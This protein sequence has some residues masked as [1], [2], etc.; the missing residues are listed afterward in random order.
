MCR[1]RPVSRVSEATRMRIRSQEMG[2]I[3]QGNN[4]LGHL[5]IEDNV[6]LPIQILA[7]DTRV[8]MADALLRLDEFGLTGRRRFYPYQLSGGERTRA[9]LAVAMACPPSILFLDEPTGEIDA[10]TEEV[11]LN[12]LE[13]H[14]AAGGAIV[15][16]TH[17]AALSARVSRVLSLKDG[18]LVDA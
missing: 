2:N 4:L 5:T 10:A 18:R 11:I 13:R 17:S 14:C 12:A 15:I 6:R 1:G 9:S 16:S 8:T 7:G 3:L